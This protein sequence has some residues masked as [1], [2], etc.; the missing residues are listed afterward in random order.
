M[1]AYKLGNLTAEVNPLKIFWRSLKPVASIFIGQR[2]IDYSNYS[3]V[4]ADQPLN[5]YGTV[6]KWIQPIKSFIYCGTGLATLTNMK[7]FELS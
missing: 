7:D 5:Y 4:L 6:L 1:Q 3:F 2:K